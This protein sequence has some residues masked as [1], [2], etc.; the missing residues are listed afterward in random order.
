MNSILAICLLRNHEPCHSWFLSLRRRSRWKL[1]NHPQPIW[2]NRRHRRHSAPTVWD[3]WTSSWVDGAACCLM[4]TIIINQSSYRSFARSIA[5]LLTMADSR[6]SRVWRL[7]LWW[8]WKG[9]K[10]AIGWQSNFDFYSAKRKFNC[11]FPL[12]LVV[13][14]QELFSLLSLLAKQES[15]D[16]RAS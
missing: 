11:F 15:C 10:K 1:M 13:F 12:S 3:C 4:I 9:F 2:W 7:S 8:W 14:L 6:A 16:C 5:C